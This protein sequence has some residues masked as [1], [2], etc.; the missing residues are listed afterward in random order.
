MGEE[1]V[2]QPKKELTPEERAKQLERLEELRVKKRKEREEREKQ[3][4]IEKEKRR[5]QE[6]KA[7]TGLKAQLEEQQMK[8]IA[9]ER[10]R[11]KVETQK[12]KERV[13]AQ[14]AADRAAKKE[15]EA[16]ERGGA[17][18]AS[19]QPAPSSAPKD[20]TETRLQIRQ[21]DGKPLVQTFKAKESLSAVRLYAQLNRK[22]LP[23]EKVNLMTTFPR[24]VFS[25]DDY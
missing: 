13:K 7:I 22:D 4:A 20:Y 11:E 21:T 23:G 16:R 9:E 5:V 17:V 19:A 8:K 3:E 12:A 14:I 10:R 15:Q 1:K 6:G 25:E 18:P 24:K 2:E